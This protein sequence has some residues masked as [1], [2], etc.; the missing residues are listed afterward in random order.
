VIMSSSR[1]DE[2]SLVLP[3]M[4]NSLFTHYMLE[5]LRG[6]AKTKGD[7]L[8]RVF[9]I[10]EYVSEKVPTCGSQHPIF[11]ASDL[12]NNFPVALYLGGKKESVPQPQTS[13]NKTVLRGAIVKHFNLEDLEILCADIQQIMLDD[14][15]VLQVDLEIVGGIS[16][17]AKVLR[18]IEYLD[19][20]GFLTYFVNTVRRSRPGII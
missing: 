3:E 4:E 6:N 20:R 15:Q 14:G 12:E 8:I 5:A 7:G 2:V 17:A 13:V 16:K 1:T 9:N 10:F 19:N 11:K 18:L